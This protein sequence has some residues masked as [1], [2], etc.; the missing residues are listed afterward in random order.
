VAETL[1]NG[2]TTKTTAKRFRVSAGR[3]SQLR[4]EL[5]QRWQDFQG[6]AVF[7]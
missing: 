7:A 4:R 3:I 6:E 1:A 2:E 5:Q